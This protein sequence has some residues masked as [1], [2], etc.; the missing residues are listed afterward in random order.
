MPVPVTEPTGTD[1]ALVP[2]IKRANTTHHIPKQPSEDIT[3]EQ[4]AGDR[5]YMSEAL[6]ARQGDQD[7]GEDD[8]FSSDSDC[9]SGSQP[10]S[11][12]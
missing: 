3:P 5:K 9:D 10:D 12:S 2:T 1:P 6:L 7:A 8:Y 11:I 4:D